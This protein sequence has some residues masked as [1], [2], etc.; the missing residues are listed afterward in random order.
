MC[1]NWLCHF[2]A[3]VSLRTLTHS[4]SVSLPINWDSLVP[5]H[6]LTVR[7]N[8]TMYMKHLTQTEDTVSSIPSSTF[9]LPFGLW[10]LP[11]TCEVTP[12]GHV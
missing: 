11:L 3:G 10:L 6:T 12:Q 1:E 2:D 7:I 9:H 4:G 5:F 8:E